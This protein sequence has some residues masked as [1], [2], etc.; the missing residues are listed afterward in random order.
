MM[1][2]TLTQIMSPLGELL[3][4]CS[5]HAVHVL[6]YSD[7]RHR[8]HQLLAQRYGREGYSL[9]E[10]S[11]PLEAVSR[12][13]AYFAGDLTACDRLP[14]DSGGTPFQQKVWL[15]LRD[16]PA[17]TAISYGTLAQRIGHATAS[18]AVGRTNAL[19]PIAIILPCHR[20]VGS[21]NAL[22]G[23]AGG[24]QRKA[25]LLRHEGWLAI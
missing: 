9:S 21:N 22:T 20:V 6:D 19:N 1:Q 16:I 25:W 7:Y 18:R 14:V 4:A 15:A 8:M 12:I 10:K 5:K 24:L 2:L 23:Y 11:D 17:G 13:K 3:L